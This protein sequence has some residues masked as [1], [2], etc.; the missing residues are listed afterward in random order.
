VSRLAWS[1]RTIQKNE[2]TCD[3]HHRENHAI[4]PMLVAHWRS[5]L[6][7]QYPLRAMTL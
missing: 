1:L 3:S 2:A 4:H 5:L 6:A 7:L